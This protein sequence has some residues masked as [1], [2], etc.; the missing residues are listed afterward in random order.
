MSLTRRASIAS[1]LLPTEAPTSLSANRTRSAV[2]TCR[3]T[4]G[5]RRSLSRG[6]R[7]LSRS[8]SALGLELRILRLQAEVGAVKIVVWVPQA[9]QP[10]DP[11]DF[12]VQREVERRADRAAFG[13][14]RIE[15]ADDLV[16]T[17]VTQDLGRENHLDRLVVERQLGMVTLQLVQRRDDPESEGR[18]GL[19]HALHQCLLRLPRSDVH[20]DDGESCDG[21]STTTRSRATPPPAGPQS[22]RRSW[23]VSASPRLPAEPIR[24]ASARL[25][26]DPASDGGQRLGA[27][28]APPPNPSRPTTP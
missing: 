19:Q 28:A 22:S 12:L 7:I 23:S 5:S 9:E 13:Q 8:S 15:R 4:S 10:K 14:G 24:G 16:R 26:P 6:F 18:I 2:L 27:R 21:S 3:S 1:S 17:I 20:Q 25:A 11:L